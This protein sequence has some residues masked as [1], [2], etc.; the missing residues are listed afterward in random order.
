MFHQMFY[1]MLFIVS[2]FRYNLS[3]IPTGILNT[4]VRMRDNIDVVIVTQS[5]P[6]TTMQ[7]GVKETGLKETGVKETGGHGDWGNRDWGN[8]DWGNVD[9]VMLTGVMWTG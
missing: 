2:N 7:T 3:K 9:W 1:H 5:I 4:G 6:I 8:V